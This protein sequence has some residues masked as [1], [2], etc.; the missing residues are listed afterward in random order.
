M[1]ISSVLLVPGDVLLLPVT[2]GVN[3]EADAVLIEG[4]CVVDESMLTGESI[5]ITKVV[6][7][8]LQYVRLF[9]LINCLDQI[10]IP[11]EESVPFNYD[12]QRQHVVF[13]GTQILQ[14]KSQAGDFCKAVVIRT[15]SYIFCKSIINKRCVHCERLLHDQ[16][17]VGPLDPLPAAARL[18]V[19]QRLP[20]VD[21]RVPLARPRRNDV[22][23]LHVDPERGN[24]LL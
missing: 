22:L 2:G 10:A 5:P 12:L 3:V 23:S 19:P 6:V 8:S 1:Q 16:G 9:D 7:D 18:Q 11:N 14:G 13:C 24:I 17:R 20:Q 4:T 21:L 15:G